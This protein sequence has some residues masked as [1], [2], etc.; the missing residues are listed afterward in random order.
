M[1][2]QGQLPGV[3]P[4]QI[5]EIE[6]AAEELRKIRSRRQALAEEEE[7]A[8]AALVEALKKNGYGPKRVY[9]FESDADGDPVKLDAFIQRPELRAYVRRHKDPKAENGAEENAENQD[10]DA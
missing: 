7:Q 10:L 2:K 6:D 5:Q 1:A 8:Q 9:I 4:K 3:G